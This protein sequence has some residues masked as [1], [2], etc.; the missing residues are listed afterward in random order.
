M[1][2]QFILLF[3]HILKAVQ[4]S[5]KHNPSSL[6]QIPKVHVPS[7]NFPTASSTRNNEDKEEDVCKKSGPILSIGELIFPE[8]PV[9]AFKD[10]VSLEEQ[11]DIIKEL[12]SAFPDLF[13]LLNTKCSIEIDTNKSSF[14]SKRTSKGSLNSTTDLYISSTIFDYSQKKYTMTT[15]CTNETGDGPN[16][17]GDG[18]FYSFDDSMKIATSLDKDTEATI[19]V[20]P[21]ELA[22]ISTNFFT[23]DC[24][25]CDPN[26]VSSEHHDE[27]RFSILI[28]M[29]YN[30]RDYPKSSP[31]INDDD[32]YT[33]SWLAHSGS[34]DFV[35]QDFDETSRDSENS[36]F[37]AFPFVADVSTVDTNF[38]VKWSV[39]LFNHELLDTLQSSPGHLM[40]FEMKARNG[41]FKGGNICDTLNAPSPQPISR[42]PTVWKP[43]K[44]SNLPTL[45]TAPTTSPTWSV[46]P[47]KS[48]IVW[49]PTTTSKMPS[50][51]N[52][53]LPTMSPT[54]CSVESGP[55]IGFHLKFPEK[56]VFAFKSSV[57][58]VEQQSIMDELETVFPDLFALLG[59]DCHVSF[60]DI[61]TSFSYDIAAEGLVNS[62]TS[63]TEYART[64]NFDFNYIVNQYKVVSNCTNS[65]GDEFFRAFTEGRKIATNVD[66]ETY[67]IIEMHPRTLSFAS[68]SI[69]NNDKDITTSEYHEEDHLRFS[70]QMSKLEREIKKSAQGSYDFEPG[71]LA[72]SGDVNF[73]FEDYNETDRDPKNPGFNAF[74]FGDNDFYFH[75]DHCLCS[76]VTDFSVDWSVRLFNHDLLSKMDDLHLMTFELQVQGISFTAGNNCDAPYVPSPQ[77]TPARPTSKLPT[78]V[79]PTAPPTREDDFDCIESGP[80]VSAVLRFPESPS[81]AFKES[82]PVE[83]QQEIIEEFEE[84]FPDLY[85]LLDTVCYLEFIDIGN[86]Y[87]WE[88]GMRGPWNNTN[89]II[90]ERAATF[91][92]KDNFYTTSTATNC[93]NKDGDGQNVIGNRFFQSFV[94]SLKIETNFDESTYG[95]VEAH[96]FALSFYSQS[97]YTN[98]CVFCDIDDAASKYYHDEDRLSILVQLYN[99]ERRIKKSP[100]SFYDF[101]PAWLAHSSAINFVK[102]SFWG[103]SRDPKKPDYSAFPFGEYIGDLTDF[104]VDWN[105]RLFNH[106]LL[107]NLD[108]GLGLMTFELQVE[109]FVFE[110]DT[111]CDPPNV[112]T[113]LP[114]PSTL[115]PSLKLP[116]IVPTTMSPVSQ[117]NL[118][119]TEIGPKLKA[120]L[121]FPEKASFVFKDSVQ[122]DIIVDELEKAF[123][124]LFSLLNSTCTVEFKN[125]G[126][127][128]Y[129]SKVAESPFDSVTETYSRSAMFDYKYREN[130]ESY[131]I[132]AECIDK[133]GNNIPSGANFF[134]LFGK[135]FK[136]PTNI[137]SETGATID[138][139]PHRTS[140]ETKSTFTSSLA[141]SENGTVVL[142]PKFHVEDH[143]SF[144]VEI[145][146][147]QR[148]YPRPDGEELRPA[149][150][151]NVGSLKFAVKDLEDTSRDKVNPGF[152]AFPFGKDITGENTDIDLEWS[153]RLFNHDLLDKLEDLKLMTF[154][155]KG[156][157]ILFTAAVPIETSTP[158]QQPNSVWEKVSNSPSKYGSQNPSVL[159]V[160]PSASVSTPSLTLH[161]SLNSPSMS[162]IS[163][164]GKSSKSTSKSPKDMEEGESSKSTI[165]SP[166]DMEKSSKS[167]SK[168]TKSIKNSSKSISKSIKSSK[169]GDVSHSPKTHSGKSNKSSSTLDV[170]DFERI[171]TTQSIPSQSN[172]VSSAPHA[173]AIIGTLTC[174][175]CI[176]VYM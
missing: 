4:I 63:T 172:N 41:F 143:F 119:Y 145:Y 79:W 118:I 144:V 142:D 11:Q 66:D 97:F 47:S 6:A 87:Y 151:P 157:D 102:K 96:P 27:D 174:L 18:F 3:W 98:A 50:I 167:K 53:R 130:F 7:V 147:N 101:E 153:V 135:G 25:F 127:S 10:S 69:F 31:S 23:K 67:A 137:D 133:Y 62:T 15:N 74:P 76:N 34:I 84:A 176:L 132:T 107:S 95:I 24:I 125:M 120:L 78:I 17:F 166:N 5:A 109:D 106:E 139:W 92:Y 121:K 165:K 86:S 128:F 33:P 83:E 68:Q 42:V 71:W 154:K 117:D 57:S 123:P 108:H 44:D 91:R 162:P 70:V 141:R 158:S 169:H 152:N 16:P 26:I 94:D 170:T 138:S 49:K 134:Q 148:E 93:T 48:P 43:T 45:T 9:F 59:A 136:I 112:P 82:V 77:P 150:L 1:K 37:H 20:H 175:L 80:R 103:A 56:P 122:R 155:L 146:H 19:E 39:R 2:S 113:P 100:Q 105:V 36:G 104:S 13:S 116:T 129:W 29:Y 54:K 32:D 90:Y 89:T 38:V 168:S 159:S 28:E 160:A 12:E 75:Y 163:K 85:S 40:T 171:S 111:V 126:D 131:T 30:E 99:E 60:I 65:F 81:F 173:F 55:L 46:H 161:P 52:P 64:A 149:W 72:Y 115:A 140:F 114:S 14:S 58:L 21:K 8:K 35:L 61:G 164:N 156:E 88:N 22:F 124:D 51:A 110:G 73:V